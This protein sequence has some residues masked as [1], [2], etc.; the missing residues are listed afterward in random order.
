MQHRGLNTERSSSFNAHDQSASIE[1]FINSKF[2]FSR[3]P[4]NYGS[5]PKSGVSVTAETPS[6]LRVQ[7][8][9][10]HYPG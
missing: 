1:K 6:I 2:I 9:M 5:F 7:Y 4:Q 3:T 10:S 8:C